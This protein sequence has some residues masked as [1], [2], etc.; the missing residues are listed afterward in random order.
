MLQD[1]DIP[2][3]EEW[4][5]LTVLEEIVMVGY[6]IGI[7]DSHN[8]MPILRRGITATHPKLNY[9]GRSEFMIDAA[10]FPGSSGSP[11]FLFNFGMVPVS[12]KGFSIGTRLK[13]LGVLYAGPQFATTGDIVTVPI[14]TQLKQIAVSS[15]PTNLGFVIK[16]TDLSAFSGIF[17]KAQS[18]KSKDTA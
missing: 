4:N 2:T 15:I 5:K 11:V 17:S 6:P 14:P 12:Q 13:L 16:S 10:C 18:S 7:W 1:S 9:E 3:E 8:N